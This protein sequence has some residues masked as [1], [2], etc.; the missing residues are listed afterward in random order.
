MNAPRSVAPLLVFAI[1]NASRGDD[2]LGPAVA[3][4]L[5]D[6]GGFDGGPDA[7]AELI[8]V[9]QLQVEDALELEGRSA[10]LFIDAV[11]APRG[12]APDAGDAACAVDPVS[13][14]RVRP[15]RSAPFTHALEPAALLDV[16]AR[17]CDQPVPPASVLAIRG[18]AFELGAP[19]SAA[20]RSRLPAALALA[21]TWL[22]SPGLDAGAPSQGVASI[23]I[24]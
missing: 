13:L 4:A 3:A 24:T 22:A 23:P 5:R 6:E 10:V 8:E 17:V 19:L 15:A 14:R 7:R 20:A 11:R 2:A 12:D 18:T 9:Y 21:R 1:G 16:A